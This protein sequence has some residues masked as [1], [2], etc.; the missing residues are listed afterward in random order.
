MGNCNT[1]ND[2]LLDVRNNSD[3]LKEVKLITAL[4]NPQ[5]DFH[6]LDQAFA[7][8]E[9]LFRGQYKGFRACNTHYHDLRHTLTVFLAMARLLHG[10]NLEGI[11]LTDKEINIGLLSALMHDAGYIQ[12]DD[13]LTGT[14]AKYTLVHIHRSS[15]FIQEYYSATDYFKDDMQNF[16]DILNCTG[17]NINI[18]KIRF[19]SP[20]IEMMGKILGTADLLGQMAD[21]FYLEKLIFLFREFAEAKVPGFASE[22]D[23]LQKTVNFYNVIIARFANNLGNVNKYMINHFRKRW[24]IEKNLYEDAMKKNIDYLKSILECNHKNLNLC[25]RRNAITI[26]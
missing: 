5:F 1:L 16:D 18:E 10:A 8:M 23:L 2:Q 25:L 15:K 3:V 9:K 13:D 4:I 26:Q 20:I 22:I 14:G 17:L 21:R 6:F 24:G 11:K 12:A 19:V 7:D